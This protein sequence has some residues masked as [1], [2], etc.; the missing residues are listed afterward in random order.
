MRR[1]IISACLDR[2]AKLVK[3]RWSAFA[4][5]PVRLSGPVELLGSRFCLA[6]TTDGRCH[7]NL[8]LDGDLFRCPAGHT[9]NTTAQPIP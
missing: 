1:A 8:T 3:I 4:F 9:W 7:E 2:L 6:K 5:V